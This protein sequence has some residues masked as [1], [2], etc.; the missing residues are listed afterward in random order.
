MEVDRA[1]ES[2]TAWRR[3]LL[4]YLTV[5][6]TDQQLVLTV[7]TSRAR[8]AG[9]AQVAVDLGL[10]LLATTLDELQS[11]LDPSVLDTRTRQRRLLSATLPPPAVTRSR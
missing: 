11:D 2:R 6:R 10:P 7:T 4:R 1:T 3:K 9:L 5:H 8:A